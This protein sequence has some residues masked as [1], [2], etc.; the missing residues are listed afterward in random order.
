MTQHESIASDLKNH[1]KTLSELIASGWRSRSVKEE[2]RENF[3]RS[4]ESSEELYPG[5]IGYQDTVLPE[6]NIALLAGHDLLFLGEKGQAKSRLMRTLV[7][8]LDEYVPYLDIPE[9]PVHEDPLRPITQQAKEFLKTHSPEETPIAWW[10]RQDRY[11]ER[12]APGT[13]FADII[14]EID[15]SKLTGGVSMSSESAL[16]FGLIPRMHRGIFAMNELPELDELVQVGLFNILE[17][18]DVQIR[19][20]PIRFDLD[21]FILFSANPSTYNRSGKVIPQLKDRIGSLIQTHYPKD[22]EQGIEIL[23]QEAGTDLGGKYPVQIP[24][25]MMEIIEEITSQA[26]ASKYV[27]QASGVSARFSL[28]N[29][30]TMIASARHRAVILKEPLAVPRIS[31]LGHLATSSLGKLELDLMGS[32]QMSERKVLDALIAS[33]IKVVFEKYVQEYG[34]AQISEIFSKGV[35]IEVGDLLPSEAYAERLKHVP[36]VWDTAFEVNASEHPA[37]RASCVEFVLSG[38]YAMDKISR[39]SK[40]GKV[41]YET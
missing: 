26:R 28:A 39:A 41:Q 2:M 40:H 30:R 11:V 3:L 38:L 29:F 19:G 1:P 20:Y 18:R 4:L 36:P 33:A 10:H 6:L 21:I 5:I 7:R 32:H 34:L 24:Y 23:L 25:F 31:D 13:K 35:R 22:R 16:H 37:I 12:L 9:V 8:F 27:D 14:G 15:P 17:E